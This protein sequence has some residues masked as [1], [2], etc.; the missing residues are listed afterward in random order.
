MY[1]WNIA[2]I[3]VYLIKLVV[4]TYWLYTYITYF[5][6]NDNTCISECSKVQ[7]YQK[8]TTDTVMNLHVQSTLNLNLIV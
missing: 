5:A 2:Q 4:S 7:S 3:L 1:R 8:Y 6:N